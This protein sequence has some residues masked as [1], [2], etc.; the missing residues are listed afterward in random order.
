M[1]ADTLRVV[2][3]YFCAAITVAGALFTVSARNPIRGALGLLLSICGIAALFLSLHAEFLAAV[4]LIVYAGAVVVLFLFAIMLLGPAAVPPSDRATWIP[5]AVGTV[6]FTLVGIAGV[7]AIMVGN[8][9]GAL[10]KF[11]VVKGGEGTI[12][13]MAHEVFGTGIVPFELSG[14]LLIVAV[15]GAIAV[16]RGRQG[17]G[18]KAHGPR[19]P[20][21]VGFSVAN[22]EA[23]PPAPT[24]AQAASSKL[25]RQEGR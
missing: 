21:K 19:T 4:Q 8:G 24:S 1:N 20:L 3:F 15:V 14:A 25:A 11:P 6:G 5:R 22:S 13:A 23:P 18:P 10:T 12:E 9:S 17:E 16:A 2:Y 7:W